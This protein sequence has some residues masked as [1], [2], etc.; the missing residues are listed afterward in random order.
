MLR[1]V[2]GDSGGPLVYRRNGGPYTLGAL[3]SLGYGC[4]LQQFPGL[5][6]P[7]SNARYLQW[8]KDEAFS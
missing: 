6:V 4:G 7:M 3:V 5:Y 1:Y 8:I 2:Q